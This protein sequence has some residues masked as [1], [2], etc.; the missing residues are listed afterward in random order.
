MMNKD[1]HVSVIIPCYNVRNYIANCLDSLINQQ[2]LPKEIICIDD[3][4][5]DDTLLIL[6]KY[7]SKYNYIKIIQQDNQGVS[8]ARNRGIE[9]ATADFV[10]FIDSDDI[11][12]ANLLHQ[13][14]S[15]LT[16]DPNLE[17]F[18]F[19][20]TFFDVSKAPQKSNKLIPL[21]QKK[22]ES[23]TDLLTYLLERKN[24]SGVVW[25]YIF[26]RD[27][28]TKNFIGKNHEDHLVSLSIISR[29]RLSYYFNNKEAYFHRV[30]SSSLSNIN[31]DSIY[32]H[33]LKNVL[34]ECIQQINKL[35]LSESAKLNYVLLMNITYLETVLKSNL[36]K[37]K[38]D[39][40]SLIQ[41]LG[42]LK[43]LIRIYT[44]N[45]PNVIRNIFYILKF[46]KLHNCSL[47][48]KK[49]LLRCAITK[50][51]PNLNIKSNYEQYSSLNKF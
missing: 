47:L 15:S 18:Y 39:K 38:K 16:S 12:N 25:R 34:K 20:Y 45:K 43:L 28:F 48:T 22:F 46:I 6:Q 1:T 32:V 26:K 2:C 40:D 49:V 27:L 7:S 51:Y 44:N 14:E 17:F 36:P 3:G 19:N 30:H 10:L 9:I 29:A 8:S 35:Q 23:G 31:I 50:Q 41:E 37:S 33:T 13:F 5:T 24:Y 11:I 42:L 21:V 4:S